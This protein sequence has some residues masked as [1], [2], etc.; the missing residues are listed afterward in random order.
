MKAIDSNIAP[1][2]QVMM[3]PT[4]EHI[5]KVADIEKDFVIDGDKLTFR[6]GAE[7]T[8]SEL[9][10]FIADRENTGTRF[11]TQARWAYY[12]AG[13]LQNGTEVQKAIVE[14]LKGMLTPSALAQLKSEACTLIPVLL[15][16]D[17]KSPLSILKD[18]IGDLT[19]DPKTNKLAPIGKQ[20]KAGKALIPLL[21]AGDV[22]QAKVRE[23]RAAHKVAPTTTTPGHSTQ[24][25]RLTEAEKVVAGMTLSLRNISTA[26][27]GAKVEGKEREAIVNI[28]T[29]VA[30][31]LGLV[32]TVPG[33]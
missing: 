26:L 24:G 6:K 15:A 11:R 23:I 30:R 4:T 20:G 29:D 22:T 21:K 5:R 27:D 9:A 28:L 10:V 1:V 17:I 3:T 12:G 8:A 16:N 33:K 31:K 18:A 14:R 32:L 13:S 25:E 2:M 19:V 7:P